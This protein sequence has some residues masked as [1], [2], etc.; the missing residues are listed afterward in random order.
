MRFEELN[1]QNMRLIGSESRIIQAAPDKNVLI[2]WGN[3]GVGKTTLLDAIAVSVAPFVSQFPQNSDR[4]LSDNDVHLN[5]DGHKAPYLSI[6]TSF[7]LPDGSL[8]SS[9]RTRKGNGKRP[10]SDVKALKAYASGLKQAIANG[11]QDVTLPIL[12]YYGT[13]RGQIKSL[14]R[15]RSFQEAFERWNCYHSALSPDTDFKTFFQWFDLMEDEERRKREQLRDFD[16]KL[17][18]LVAVRRAISEFMPS[19]FSNP[20]IE[21]H[22]LRFVMDE[23]YDGGHRQ[24]RIE[25]LS[26]GYKIVLAMVA[27]IAARMAEANPEAHEI[28]NTPGIV[29]I[30]DAELHLHPQ[31]QRTIIQQLVRTFPQVQFIVS[32]HSPIIVVGASNIAQV[33]QLEEKPIPTELQRMDVGQ[34]LLSNL[35]S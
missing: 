11:H 27:D 34:V 7:R 18:A 12:A 29:L 15:K 23:L 8:I 20:H 10:D 1:V 6:Q 35:F 30:D 2:L 19:R 9:Y 16:Y 17:P 33:V 5:Q 25:Q 21:I 24:L 22:P 26:D 14:E 13:G 3:N 31:W 28:L 4:L 32:T